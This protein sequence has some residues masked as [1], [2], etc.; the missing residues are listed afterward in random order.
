MK[1]GHRSGDR[2]DT[3]LT[4]GPVFL[5]PAPAPSQSPGRP[6]KYFSQYVDTDTS[7]NES[8]FSGEVL[9][10]ISQRPLNTDYRAER[11]HVSCD[12]VLELVCCR[13]PGN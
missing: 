3:E 2:G 6:I 12:C 5:C 9:S 7:Y 1:I 11:G 8:M 4:L 10:H 13:P